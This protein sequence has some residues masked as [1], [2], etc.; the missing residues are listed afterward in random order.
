MIKLKGLIWDCVESHILCPKS[1]YGNLN[2]PK[3]LLHVDGLAYLCFPKQSVRYAAL[4]YCWG[5]HKMHQTPRS[6][7]SSCYESMDPS[8]LPKTMQRVIFL[9]KRLSVDYIWINSLCIVQ[10]SIEK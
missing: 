10:Y 4:G 1:Q 3:R 2:M 6:H 7:V 5:G 9:S 8:N